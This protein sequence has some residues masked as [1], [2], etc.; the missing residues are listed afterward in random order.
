MKWI[1]S[2]KQFLNEAKI[3]DVIFKKQSDVVSRVWGEKYLDYEE[4]DPTE[5][6]EQGK[7]KLS[8]EDKNRV[9]SAFFK[10][11]IQRI[12]NDLNS[13]PDKFN[14]I[15]SKS[16]D[17]DMISNEKRRVIL[18]NLNIKSPTIDQMI[19]IFDNVFRKLSIS[20]TQATEMIQ[21]DENGRP[22][23]DEEGNMLRIQKEAGD[24]IFSN[25][26]VNINS[27]LSDYNRCYP[28]DRVSGDVFD[29]RDFNELR[30][31]ASIDEN[32][33]YD[34]A[35]MQI[36]GK[37]VYLYITHNAK[38]ILNMSIS[39][40]YS[41]CQHLY[42]GG[43]RRQVL[44]NVFDPNSMPAFLIFETPIFWENEKINDFLPL[45]RMVIRDLE[46]TVSVD[47]DE[48]EDKKGKLFFDRAYP[49]RMRTIFCEII[50]KY[51]NN[52]EYEGDVGRYIFSPDVDMEDEI[53]DPYMDRLGI[54]K[55][56]FI[57]KNVK[58]LYLNRS[59]DWSKVKISPTA[60]VKEIIIETTDL[61]EN[62][63][64][65]KLKP[66]WVKFR[67][68]KINSL[69][70]FSNMTTDSI[71]FDKCK[72][73]PSTLTELR[74]NGV[75]KIQIISCDVPGKLDFSDFDNLEELH[76]VY[77]SENLDEV[78]SMNLDKIK[79]LVISG[80]LIKTKEDK[81]KINELKRVG[82]KIE[83]VGPVI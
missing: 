66:E 67:F 74:E 13:L 72:I 34:L 59:H 52:K 51:T 24:P 58:S 12:Y 2:R 20:E 28:D 30:N 73:E 42:S 69:K 8:D 56:P 19:F 27:F 1:K 60:K 38:D 43:Y 55:K 50:E 7:W 65:I 53:S 3:R 78:L 75:K 14:D 79:K 5:N 17:I 11:D 70:P 31:I 4:V 81:Q 22:V 63:A 49:D 41:S 9:L 36:F 33:D 23:R 32:S 26:L 54:T 25:N 45:S 47:S 40:F 57:G 48:E 46:S 83:I 10:S 35:D 6:I 44:G 39:K 29:N 61:P 82:K 76:V 77:S 64:D 16:L 71:S 37:D 15:L 21:K 80:D 18:N 62:F 68:L